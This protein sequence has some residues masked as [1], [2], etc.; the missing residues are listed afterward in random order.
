MLPNSTYLGIICLLFCPTVFCQCLSVG[1]NNPG[2]VGN[3]PEVGNMS[4]NNTTD[5]KSSNNDRSFSTALVLG[6]ITNYLVATD[7]GFS[8]PSYA[9]VCG[10][11][12]EIE[13]RATGLLESVNDHSVMIV[14]GEEVV[15]T[16]HA[17]GGI[18]P[19]SDTYYTYGSPSD[20]WGVTWTAAEINSPGFG[21]AI[22]ANLFGI[23]VL[24][25]SQV[26]HIRITVYYDLSLPV[27]LIEFKTECQGEN[28]KLKWRIASQVNNDFFTVQRSHDGISFVD[29]AIIDG[30]GTSTE[31]IEYEFLD[32]NPILGKSYYRLQQTDTDGNSKQFETT[33]SQCGTTASVTIYPNPA[34]DSYSVQFENANNEPCTITICDPFGRVVQ[35]ITNITSE[36]IEIDASELNK[37]I[38]ILQVHKN[39]EMITKSR[40]QIE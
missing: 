15:G 40:L 25:S 18:W 1:P 11:E 33:E 34:S 4:W 27:D 28:V 29:L 5:A 36:K 24:P 39:G 22:S 20:T 14:N 16:E 9:I 8:I 7:F 13:K 26:D 6:D 21:V 17:V 12:A 38:Y 30:A 2:S 32:T 19:S 37:G 35:S 10:I 23:T 31:E 3:D